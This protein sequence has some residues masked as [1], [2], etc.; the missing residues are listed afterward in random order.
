MLLILSPYTTALLT[1]YHYPINDG[2]RCHTQ[3]VDNKLML[4]FWQIQKMKWRYAAAADD[5]GDDGGSASHHFVSA[6]CDYS[7][8]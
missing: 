1:I 3:Y 6:Q 5:D 4:N 2:T 7:Q 8:P